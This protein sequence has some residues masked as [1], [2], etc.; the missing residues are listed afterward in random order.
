MSYHVIIV[1]GKDQERELKFTQDFSRTDAEARRW[2]DEEFVK[3]E[4][5]VATPTGKILI[6]DKILAVARYAGTER[7][8]GDWGVQFAQCVARVLNRD[9]IRVDIPNHII[10]Y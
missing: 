2:L 7:L 6:I 8:L 9:L 3:L 1:L 10:G 4:C 5:D